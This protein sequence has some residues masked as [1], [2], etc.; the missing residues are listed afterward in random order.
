MRILGIHDGHT[1][2]ACLFDDGR[3]VAMVS[4][5]RFSRKKNQSGFPKLAVEWLVKKYGITAK[6]LDLVAAPGLVMPMQEFGKQEGPWYYLASTLSKTVPARIMGSHAWVRSYLA[7]RS[8]GEPRIKRLARHLAPHAIPESKI[9][10]VEHHTCH[11]HAAYWLDHRR[12]DEQTL[13]ITLDNTGDGLCGSVSIAKGPNEFTRI[14]AIPSLH[15]IGMMYTAITRY[16]GM[17][18]V[19][20]EH[21]VM[22]LAPYAQGPQGDVVYQILRRHMDLSPDRLTIVNKTG[23]WEDAYV[24]SFLTELA[25]FR[26]D[27]IAAGVQRLLEELV[28]AYL[29]AWSRRTGIRKLA[30]GGGVFMNVKLNMLINGMDDFDDVYFLPSCGDESIAA[31][32]ALNCEWDLHRSMGKRFDPEPL[33]SLCLGLAF[34]NE[35]VEGVLKTYEGRLQW[36]KCDDIERKTAEM[37][38]ANLLVGRM[39]GRMEFGAR[40]LGNRSILAQADSLNNVRRINAAIKMRDFWM[41]FA[42]ALLWERRHDYIV[43]PKERPAPYMILAFPSTPLAEQELIAALHPRDLSCRPQLV[44]ADFNPKFYRLLK[45]YEK[46]TGSGGVLN[47]SFNIHGEPIVCSPTDAI[48]TYLRSDLD[49]LTIEDYL[50]WDS[51][52]RDPRGIRS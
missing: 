42:P 13:V 5:E 19:E 50:I 10:L 25:S 8:L 23:F 17:K 9:R 1:A 16:L 11:A 31:G 20:D 38:A 2:T 4:E 24:Q 41:P 35:E 15:S 22:G 44:D 26:F 7:L 18:P 51:K 12:T 47:T 40:A 30:L 21:K 49:A 52:R 48:D 27:H 14:R 29:R 45:A 3:I 33:G 32:A 46:M 34:S 36:Q 39:S 37:L 28:T 43:N 6:D